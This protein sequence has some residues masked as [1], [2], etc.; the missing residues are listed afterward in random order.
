[1]KIYCTGCG[2]D[3]EARLTN[4]KEHYPSRPDLTTYRFGPVIPVTHGWAATIRLKSLRGRLA[5]WPLPKL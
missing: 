4:G 2:K 5:I 3:V 1:M